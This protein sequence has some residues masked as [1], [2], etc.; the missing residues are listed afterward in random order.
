MARWM[1]I[2][3]LLVAAWPDA[4]LAQEWDPAREIARDTARCLTMRAFRSLDGPAWTE[5]RP[6]GYRVV[7]RPIEPGVTETL[8]E[9]IDVQQLEDGRVGPLDPMTERW[10]PY[11]GGVIY[12]VHGGAW[13]PQLAWSAFACM[14]Q[15]IS[16]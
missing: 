7:W 12:A 10:W 4:A 15:R 2:L 5:P 11:P 8:Y 13:D 9:W 3:A 14:G 1:L 6:Q 16:R